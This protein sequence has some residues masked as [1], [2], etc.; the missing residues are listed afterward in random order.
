M[1]LIKINN[2]WLL[3]VLFCNSHTN[4]NI[5][6]YNA[7]VYQFIEP[8]TMCGY[9]WMTHSHFTIQNLIPYTYIHTVTIHHTNASYFY[10]SSSSRQHA[11]A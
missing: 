9:A 3:L 8:K 1:L 6:N 7:I 4:V 5:A 10:H 2:Y 11:F